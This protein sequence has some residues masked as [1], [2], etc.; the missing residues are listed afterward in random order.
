MTL[1]KDCKKP[2]QLK[3]GAM[4]ANSK[5]INKFKLPRIAVLLCTRDGSRFIDQ[6]LESLIN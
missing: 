3:C 1:M 4:L 5:K 2:L 6:Q